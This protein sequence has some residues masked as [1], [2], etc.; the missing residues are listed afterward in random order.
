M[1]FISKLFL[2]FTSFIEVLDNIDK[3]LKVKFILLIFILLFVSVFEVLGIGV[4]FP[5]LDTLVNFEESQFF[6]YFNFFNID[7]IQNKNFF[8]TTTL[9]FLFIIFLI[10]N[11]LVLYAL[12]YVNKFFHNIELIISE[13]ILKNYIFFNNNKE[14]ENDFSLLYK[15]IK[16][17]VL[18]FTDLLKSQ[19]IVVKESVIIIF[20]SILTIYIQPFYSFI[21]LSIFFLMGLLF[22]FTFKNKIKKLGQ[23][24]KYH[25]LKNIHYTTTML[26][27][28]KEIS[29]FNVERRFIDKIINHLSKFQ[30]LT[31][32]KLLLNNSPKQIFEIVGLIFL[33]TVV[34]LNMY[35]FEKSL[36]E[37][38]SVVIFFG[39]IFYRIMP[40][41][42]L[43]NASLVTINYNDPSHQI[44][45]S[46]IK[47]SEEMEIRKKSLS[48]VN[49][50]EFKNEI[51]INNLSF[52]YDQ[53]NILKKINLKI[54]KNNHILL[55][56][57]SGSGKSTLIKIICGILKPTSG[58]IMI[59]DKKI[60]LQNI[61]S[62]QEKIAIVPQDPF[63]MNDTV[64][65]NITL[66][67]PSNEIDYEMLKDVCKKCEILKFI[68]D[69]PN[70]FETMIG[71][72][73]EKI[74]GGQKQR[75]SIAR[76]LYFDKDLLVL[77]E[78]TNS[79]D[80][81]TEEK[82]LNN[83][84]KIEN[85]TIILISHKNNTLKNL[86]KHYIMD[87]GNLLNEVKTN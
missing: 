42:S 33:L 72:H 29:F 37:I 4:I 57:L 51:K 79:L 34:F 22:Y 77:D 71:E 44:I 62:W 84:L 59:D 46:E 36:T 19:I 41:I 32:I 47:K 12:N 83:I 76:A 80:S 61:T 24:R 73:G 16:S 67:Q 78:S 28:L 82:L 66:M 50:I 23:S 75:I 26:S 20:L 11:F 17:E 53:I 15:N 6:A 38:M 39:I 14:F 70:K 9:I 86:Y 65:N 30:Y 69:L 45:V 54:K 52:S 43:I 2:N 74:S 21:Q 13:K 49:S 5:V 63:I 85:L 35:I 1:S 68:E 40:S 8:I 48:K 56:G 27:G 31:R 58:E 10:K 60:D 64:L 55:S 81:E 18:L 25:E 87:N 7:T 3:K